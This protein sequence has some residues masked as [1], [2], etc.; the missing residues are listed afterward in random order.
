VSLE[1]Q[2]PSRTE[3]LSLIGD[4]VNGTLDP[5]GVVRLENLLM[6]SPEARKV[7]RRYMNLHAAM[8]WI[9]LTSRGMTLRRD[10]QQLFSDELTESEEQTSLLAESIE[11][12]AESL[13]DAMILPAIKDEIEEERSPGESSP[14][15]DVSRRHSVRAPAWRRAAI[16]VLP[17]MLALGVLYL[18]RG[19]HTHPATLGASVDASWGAP[20]EALASGQPM[21]S[22]PIHLLS[23]LAEV[24]FQNGVSVVLQGPAQFE[25]RTGSLGELTAGKLTAMVPKGGEGFAVQTPSARIVD[26]GTE[27]GVDVNADQQTHAEVFRGHV[28]AEVSPATSDAPLSKTLEVNQAVLIARGAKSIQLTAPTPLAFVRIAELQNQAQSRPSAAERWLVCSDSLRHDPGIV[29]YY[30]FDNAR[31][32]PDRLLNRAAATAGRFDGQLGDDQTGH[33]PHWSTGRWSGKGALDFDAS[34]RT[35][36]SLPPIPMFVDSPTIT[37]AAWVLP[38]DPSRTMHILDEAREAQ[39]RLDFVWLGAH[40]AVQTYGIYFD[41]GGGYRNAFRILPQERRWTFLV[42]TADAEGMMRFYVDGQER[43]AISGPLRKGS[44]SPLVI[45][46]PAWER[47]GIGS[48]VLDGSMDEFALFNRVLSAEEIQAVYNAGKPEAEKSAGPK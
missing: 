13:A 3:L 22:G 1:G 43:A 31:E 34:R 20:Y 44:P 19:A 37:V 9:A 35:C 16:I 46:R 15:G 8:G 2:S 30:T 4:L 10:L 27:F 41:R 29:A 18:M 17:L 42:V 5:A 25:V 12:G 39:K 38:K 23:G 32:V 26:L 6:T 11:A 45:G 47:A 7:Y 28:R 21:P 24:R 48:Q 36:V 33:D 14:I 40:A